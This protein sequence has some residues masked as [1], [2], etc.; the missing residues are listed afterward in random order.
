M[1][2]KKFDPKELKNILTPLQYRVTQ[3]KDTERP[4]SG[5]Y[6]K[7]FKPGSYLCVVCQQK[8]FGSDVKFDSGCGWPAFYDSEKN[9]TKEIMDK[10]H[11]MT[12]IEVVCSQCNAHLGHVFD[13]GPKPTGRRFC[14]NS[15]SLKFESK[16]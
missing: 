7:F 2:S 13:D 8:L 11:G 16:M 9:S 3:E 14:I 4:F 5:E 12:R 1:D 6:D 15:A 10:S